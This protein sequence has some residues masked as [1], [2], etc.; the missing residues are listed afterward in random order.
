L[1]G[2]RGLY[3]YSR[4]LDGLRVEEGAQ[5]HRVVSIDHDDRT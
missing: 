5:R 4:A 2:I 1:D 3:C